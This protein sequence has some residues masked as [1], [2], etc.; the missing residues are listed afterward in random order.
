MLT[1]SGNVFPW[2]ILVLGCGAVFAIACGGETDDPSGNGG[3]GGVVADGAADSLAGGSAGTGSGGAAGQAGSA[4][5]VGVAGSAGSVGVAGSAGSV[6]VAGSAGSV[7]VAGSAGGGGDECSIGFGSSTCHYC[8]DKYCHDSCVASESEPSVDELMS[9]YSGC[10]DDACTA[11]CD[12]TY[13]DAAVSAT[14]L[15]ECMDQRC[16][17]FCG[18]CGCGLVQQD[19]ICDE[20]MNV[21]CLQA[22]S[23]ASAVTTADYFQ[24]LDACSDPSCLEACDAAYPEAAAGMATLGECLGDQCATEC[25]SFL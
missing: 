21:F 7:G 18:P 20:C 24:C 5:S 23:D 14:A 1:Q 10:D 9:C 15:L 3:S 19:P 6:G 25:A 8:V 16:C 11:A 2:P 12:V 4:G 17:T 13:P 22:C